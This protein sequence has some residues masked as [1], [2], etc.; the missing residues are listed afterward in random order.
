M[1]TLKRLLIV[2]IGVYLTY[3]SWNVAP[4]IIAV[5]LAKCVY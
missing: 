2:S 4:L 3:L 5:I 1:T